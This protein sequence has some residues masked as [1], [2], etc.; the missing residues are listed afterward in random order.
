[1]PRHLLS[2][3][4]ALALSVSGC[5]TYRAVNDPL[6]R[7]DPSYGYLAE[8][9]EGGRD[10][11]EMAFVLAFS[12]GGTRA[13][14]LS[15]GVLQELRDTPVT[16]RGESKRLLDE[17]DVISS[18]SGGSFTSA[19]Y[20]LFGDRIFEDFEERF[21]RRNVQGRLLLELLRPKNWI[22]LTGTFFARSEIA[23]ELYD[24]TIFDHATF[25]D[26]AAASGPDVSINAT[27]LALGNRFSFVQ[28]QFDPICSD[29]GNLKV[30]RAVAA[31]SAV[32]VLLSPI[33]L[34]SYA[35]ECDYEAPAWLAEALADR[36]G[37]RRRLH[38]ARLLERYMTGTSGRYLHLV[39]GGIADNLG[40]RGPLDNVIL[41]G[42]LFE[43][44]AAL[45][46][47]R[48][49]IV[50]VLVVNAA[51]DPDP[52]FS[53][54]A[55]A[56]GMGAILGSVTEAQI[57]LYNF[58]TLEL[59]RASMESW[60]REVPADGDGAGIETYLVEVAFENVRDAEERKFLRNV[61][62]S[63]KLADETVDRLIAAGRRLLRESPDFQELLEALR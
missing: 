26:L 23:I 33:T 10:F 27:D 45:G 21:L 56:P 32:P 58:E 3:L 31:S 39:D 57:Q 9:H 61:P 30:A 25:N 46:G 36:R 14:A 13:A 41:A 1:M 19:Y 6:E 48:P 62:T 37:S 34:R 5:S 53:L 54:S 55:A 17:V 28:P 63:F 50:V 35:G 44:M 18:V 2:V 52:T 16:V 20:G 24:R 60:A 11:G 51:A 7:Y 12:G 4:S 40:L 47:T 49:K 42:G 38:G 8:R 22:R 15:Y 43:R 29:L 59:M